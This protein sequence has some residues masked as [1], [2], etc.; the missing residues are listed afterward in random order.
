LRQSFFDNAG[1][2]A[3]N[4]TTVSI[5]KTPP[6][7]YCAPTPALLTPGAGLVPASIGI[8]FDDG[9]EYSNSSLGPAYVHLR[10]V[11][12]S[13]P[14]PGDIVDWAAGTD[15]RD[16]LLLAPAG[17][18]KTVYTFTYD[19]SDLAGNVGS[20]TTTITVAWPA[21]HVTGIAPAS[22]VAG[23]AADLDLVITGDGF[24]DGATVRWNGT[25]L[26]S[27]FVSAN[28]VRATVPAALLATAGGMVITVEN[29][30]PYDGVPGSG[31]FLLTKAPVSVTS[32]AMGQATPDS[33]YVF[34]Q[35]GAPA[36]GGPTMW[37]WASGGEGTVALAT[38]G[39]DPG[40]AFAGGTSFFD[41]FVSPGA[42]LQNLSVV[43]CALGGASQV[44]WASPQGWRLA[45]N[46]TF[47]PGSGG[48]PDCVEVDLDATDTF[49]TIAQLAGTYF[50][51]GADITPPTLVL[52][53]PIS[54]MASGS[55]GAAVTYTASATDDTD[56][57]PTVS[58]A[59][60][61]GSLFPIGTTTVTCTATDATGHSST[62]SF[63]V[64]V[65]QPNTDGRMHGDGFVE[66]GSTKD[67]FEFDVAARADLDRGHFN[68]NVTAPKH[69]STP[70]RHD[71]FTSTSIDVATFANDP[72]FT[73]G[74]KKQPP[75]TDSVVFSGK[76]KWNGKSGYTFEVSATDRGEPG[77]GRDTFAVT[78][79]NAAGAV[80]ESVS[81][82]LAGGNVQ[83]TRLSPR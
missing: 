44:F 23:T 33:P 68:Y 41:V 81:G 78:I 65:V 2:R 79:K 17:S 43:T 64:T 80:V 49:P 1:N 74:R 51:A 59:P 22:A 53:A 72:A 67:H 25:T 54:V 66:E 24:A 48:N 27:S 38:Y 55:S 34:L 26:S 29:P 6:N 21:S 10:S 77:V 56:P 15:D 83:S 12:S 76:G 32:I 70:E 35:A 30:A 71:Q 36:D 28:E 69:G 82:V 16:G 14:Q 47:L 40:T 19:A 61:S 31:V 42:T 52:P 46:Q 60:P 73:P 11:T 5:D 9:D 13:R 4:F 75:A 20:C 8:Y 58:C 3:D 45:T 18:E 7:L 50:A 62:G 57:A 39:G 37:V 63:T